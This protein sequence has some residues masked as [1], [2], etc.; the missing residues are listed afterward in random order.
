MGF[1]LNKIEKTLISLD[2]FVTIHS[3]YLGGLRLASLLETW[4]M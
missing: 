2:S 3:V 1:V 4:L